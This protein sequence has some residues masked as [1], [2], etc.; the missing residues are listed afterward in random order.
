MYLNRNKSDAQFL[1]KEDKRLII[2]VG[3]VVEETNLEANYTPMEVDEAAY[4]TKI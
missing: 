4:A 1:V 3:E 2:K